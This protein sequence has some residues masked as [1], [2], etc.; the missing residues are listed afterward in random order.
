MARPL[1]SGLRILA[2]CISISVGTA[3]AE[4]SELPNVT[5]TSQVSQPQSI[6]LSDLLDIYSNPSAAQQLPASNASQAPVLSPHPAMDTLFDSSSVG[7]AL[8]QSAF[9]T[10]G[11]IIPQH[12]TVTGYVDADSLGNRN[13]YADSTFAPFSGIYESGLRLRATG[14]ASWYRFITNENPRTLGSGRY[15]EGDFLMGYG[16]WTPRFN[17]TG[18]A[19]PAFAQ[20][21]N[22]GTIT[23]HWGVKTS[24]EVSARPTD[25]TVAAGSI[26]YS[27]VTND[28]QAQARAGLKIFDGVYV[29]PEAKLQ[30][31]SADANIA[32]MHLGAFSALNVGRVAVGISGGWAHDRQLGSGSYGSASLYVPF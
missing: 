21:D 7:T 4:D 28:L 30:S 31:V 5:V 18:L 6:P 22:L 25:W 26:S 20:I 8:T 23:D 1:S 13:V 19:G 2:L 32:Y 17:V 14:D 12:I 10:N 16:Y 15:L 27:T 3:F 11:P 24:I 29:G 9:A